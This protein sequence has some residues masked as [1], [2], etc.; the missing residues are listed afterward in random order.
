MASWTEPTEFI[1]I[2]GNKINPN[3]GTNKIHIKGTDLLG[4]CDGG[5]NAQYKV[6]VA[7]PN[8]TFD[9]IS[10]LGGATQTGAKITITDGEGGV[11]SAPITGVQLVVTIATLSTY[12]DTTKTL[13]AWVDLMTD[14][15]SCKG[16]VHFSTGTDGLTFSQNYQCPLGILVKA[17]IVDS[18]ADIVV[19]TS[20]L[21]VESGANNA[22]VS[23]TVSYWA[24]GE[25]PTVD[26]PT[27]TILSTAGATTTI[28]GAANGVWIFMITAYVLLGTG[29]SET[30]KPANYA[31]TPASQIVLH[32]QS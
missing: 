28:A 16:V 3:A 17:K 7:A 13:T 4:C 12:L 24:P 10:L 1:D 30:I 22:P 2:S 31:G 19:T 29:C 14:E 21:V 32:T 23:W 26:A 20:G 15:G 5:C 6:T 27:G 18:G 11:Y 8:V 9:L 25:D